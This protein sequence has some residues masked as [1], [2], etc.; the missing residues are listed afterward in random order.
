MSRIRSTRR[1]CC[2]GRTRSTSSS[3]DTI[4][5]ADLTPGKVTFKAVAHVVGARD[6]LLGDNEAIAPA[7]KIRP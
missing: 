5:P 1:R 3:N 7:T 4:T 2:A 6:A